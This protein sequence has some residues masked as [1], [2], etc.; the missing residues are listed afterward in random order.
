MAYKQQKWW[1]MTES[2]C[3]SLDANQKLSHLTNPPNMAWAIFHHDRLHFIAYRLYARN[4]ATRLLSVMPPRNTTYSVR[5]PYC[6]HSDTHTDKLSHCRDV[7]SFLF[8]CVLQHQGHTQSMAGVVGIEP[9]TEW[10]TVTW[11]TADLHA[12]KTGSPIRT[13]TATNSFG[14]CDATNYIIGE[15]SQ[16]GG[17][18]EF[19]NLDLQVKSPL[20]CLW[21]TH[22]IT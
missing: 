18:G 3:Q 13:R 9:T 22:P 2:N 1:R 8:N 20:L 10:L 15:Q 6:C 16:N 7:F 17:C 4:H 11:S 21:V 19:R 5:P 14:D 12:N